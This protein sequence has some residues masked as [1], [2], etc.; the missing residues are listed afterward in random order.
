MTP[1]SIQK[2]L[3]DDRRRHLA[4][5]RR[6]SASPLWCEAQ[7]PAQSEPRRRR[8]FSLPVV[9]DSRWEARR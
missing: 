6:G 4:A 1:L 9:A 3:I 7:R 2:E 5:L 8:A